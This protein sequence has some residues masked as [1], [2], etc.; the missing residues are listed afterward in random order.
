M[1]ECGVIPPEVILQ[2]ICFSAQ[3]DIY[4]ARQLGRLHTAGFRA[5][6]HEFVW[7]L[8]VPKGS[9]VTHTRSSKRLRLTGR[10]I[11]RKN[12]SVARQRTEIAHVA[13]V[14]MAGNKEKSLT[15]GRLREIL[16]C[17]GPLLYINH[18]SSIGGTLLVECCRARYTTE[19]CI[20]RC[21]KEH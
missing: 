9:N 13:L 18:I 4:L 1:H 19:S 17:W 16:R 11:V 12:L 8:L 7:T 6:Y 5:M 20:I 2:I 21:A 14:E 3:D 15:L 10:D